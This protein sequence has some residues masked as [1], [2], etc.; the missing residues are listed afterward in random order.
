MANWFSTEN[1]LGVN[2]LTNIDNVAVD[3]GTSHARYPIGTIV[4]GYDSTLGGGEFVYLQGVANNLVGLVVSYNATTGATV[5]L[6]S[7]AN[8]ATP[9]AVSLTAN[10]V[11]TDYSWYQIAGLATVLKSAVAVNPQ[12]KVYISGTAGRFMPTSVSG[13]AIIGAKFANLATVT[14]TTS[15]VTVLLSRPTTQ[16]QIT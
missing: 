12:A 14:S 6:P 7:T 8:L 4:Q 1:R 10:A 9:C 3:N 15:T 2:A 5:V 13:K 11:A 16:T